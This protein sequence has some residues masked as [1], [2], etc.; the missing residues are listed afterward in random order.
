[1]LDGCRILIVDDDASVRDFLCLALDEEGCLTAA[2]AGAQ[3]ALDALSES[4]FDLVLLDGRLGADEGLELVEPIRRCR[5]DVDVIMMTGFASTESAVAAVEC[6]VAGYLTKPLDLGKLTARISRVMKRRRHLRQDHALYEQARRELA[7]R[8]SAEEALRA[9]EERFASFMKHV[10]GRAFIKDSEGRILY[11]NEPAAKALGL[12]SCDIQGMYLRELLSPEVAERLLLQDELVLDSGRVSETEETLDIDGESRVF[13]TKRFPIH[14]AGDQRLLGVLR[15]DIT[16]RKR[17][18]QALAESKNVF[19]RLF[20]NTYL[21][22]AHLDRD[23]NFIRV[24]RAYA[25]AD[26]QDP[27]FF[28]GKNHFDLYPNADNQRIFQEVVD[29]GAPYFVYEKAFVYPYR[30]GVVTYWDWSLE[31]IKDAQGKVSELVL[32][33]LNVTARKQVQKELR[34]L[35][36]QLSRAEE[37]ERRRMAAALHDYIGQSLSLSQIMLGAL[38]QSAPS[39][40]FAAKIDEVRK[41]IDGSLKDTRALIFD[42]SPPLLYEVGLRAALEKLAEEFEARHDLE[43]VCWNDKTTLSL[44]ESTRILLFQAVRELLTNAAKHSGASMV[45]IGVRCEDGFV[46]ITVSDDGSGFDADTAA[47]KIHGEGGFGLFN[48]RERMESIGG[49]LEI[50]SRPGE[51]SSLTLVA[52]VNA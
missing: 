44:S 11:L 33:L 35:A 48:I 12:E 43:C 40:D 10:P 16:E 41:L 13:L 19:E 9:S 22:I 4:E 49:R 45:Q 34:S 5:P 52:Q 47:L 2:A 14:S 29:T 26:G 36:H 51:G 20:D 38:R 30:P 50:D 17:A 15:I 42:L 32:I 28:P 18:E 24:N 31:P 3:E 21:L 27:D 46:R 23:F 1:M 37:T 39:A 7:E 6:D 25:A 8:R